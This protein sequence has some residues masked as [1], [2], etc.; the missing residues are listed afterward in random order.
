MTSQAEAINDI[1]HYGYLWDGT[2]PGWTLTRVHR[3]AVSLTVHFGDRGPTLAEMKAV[4]VIIPT[5]NNRSAAAVFGELRG[6]PKLDLGSFEMR[7]GRHISKLCHD[8][9]LTIEENV[10]DKSGYLPVNELT[11]IALVIEDDTL[12]LAVIE[13]ALRR[14]VPVKHLET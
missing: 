5:Y 4:R 10:Q 6:K 14:G 1:K 12:F 13:E 11:N 3:Q 7:E 8:H 2:Q 9:G